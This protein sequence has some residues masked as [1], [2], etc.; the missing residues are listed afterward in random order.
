MPLNYDL[1]VCGAGPAGC[2]A[3][4]EAARAGLRVAL[5]EKATLPRYKTCGGGMPA[6][7]GELFP[8]LPV[9]GVIEARVRSLRHTWNFSDPC[10]GEINPP[11]TERELSLWMVQRSLF[12]HALA[13]RAVEC[14]AELREGL[15]VRSIETGA[16]GVTVRAGTPKG[17]SAFA[18]TADH[19]IGADGANGVAAQASGLRRNRTVAV[20]MEAEVPHRWGTGHPD[21]RPEVAHL[22]Y[23][24]V[25]YGYAWVFPKEA[26]LSIG[27]GV[28]NAR[29]AGRSDGA[30]AQESLRQA[31]FRYLELLGIARSPAEV[32]FHAHPVPVWR[33]GESL[34]TADGRILLAGDAAGLVHPLF[35][36][37][38]LHALKSGRI[39]ARCLVEGVPQEYTRRIHREVTPGFD[40]ALT[41]SRLFYEW[42]G[43]LYRYG[44]KRPG[45]T[46]LATRLL[47]GESLS[48]DL[49]GYLTRRVRETIRDA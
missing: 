7:V 5:L 21:L 23:G 15:T 24:A 31:V 27:A 30:K 46:R 19:L 34:Q 45:A 33:G 16:S 22:E 11:G 2:S 17:E 4:A 43:P 13:R 26:H 35:G 40:A 10:L 41:L 12:D 8:D 49:A 18:A 1:I 14:G 25:K 29:Q 28:F 48:P 36:D 38:I 32:R 20:A 9:D 42:A 39:A 44:V 47:S 3:A 6:A 37:G